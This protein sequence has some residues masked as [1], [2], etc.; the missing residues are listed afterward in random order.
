MDIK[1]RFK[2]LRK[3]IGLDQKSFAK[4]LGIATGLVGGIESGSRSLTPAVNEKI[5]AKYN[6]DILK[7][8][9]TISP[10]IIAVKLYM[11]AKAA[12]GPGQTLPETS[13]ENVLYFDKRWLENTIGIK[14]EN[15]ILIQTKGNSMD[16]GYNKLDDIKDGDLLLVDTSIKNVINNKIFV[17]QQGND[18]RVKRLKKELN[19]EIFLLSNNEKDFPPEMVK[20]ESFIIGRVV[21]NGSKECV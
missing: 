18:L 21:W 2:K 9:N 11:D 4:E 12:A 7:E 3:D 14:A 10:N 16:S 1:Q 6:I 5:I 13:E 17:I 8:A 19:G 15:A 20:E